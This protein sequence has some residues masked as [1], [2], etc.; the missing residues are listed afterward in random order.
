MA[1]GDDVKLIG[2]WPSPYYM[3]ARIALN[4]KSVD[5]QFIAENLRPKSELL[6]KVN[7]VYK[8]IPVLIHGENPICES[9]IIVQYIDE[10]WNS[11]GPSILP[12]DPYD[13]AI[14]RFWAG[15]IDDTVSYPFLSLFRVVHFCVK[16]L[17]LGLELDKFCLC[18][19]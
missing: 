7:P 2:L 3:R 17:T 19:F 11:S 15:Y 10:V 8:K 9:L 16:L 5:Y 6:H 1:S 12:S 4:I 18:F 14:S 13:R